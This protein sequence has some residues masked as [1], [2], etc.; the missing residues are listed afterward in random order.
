MNR[1]KSLLSNGI[2]RQHSILFPFAIFCCARTRRLVCPGS[3]IAKPG[4]T[5]GPFVCPR[6]SASL[7]KKCSGTCPCNRQEG[8]WESTTLSGFLFLLN[9]RSLTNDRWFD[10]QGKARSRPGRGRSTDP[11]VTHA[12]G[13]AVATTRPARLGVP[14]RAVGVGGCYSQVKDFWFFFTTAKKKKA[15]H[16]GSK[17]G[18]IAVAFIPG[19]ADG[20]IPPATV[21]GAGSSC[22]DDAISSSVHCADGFLILGLADD[23]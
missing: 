5:S 4:T 13:T 20:G 3:Q 7:A 2:S 22:D 23:A 8:E 10:S 21:P 11:I 17:N 15:K 18:R 1:F 16:V 6:S 9:I 19:V 14:S 12:Q